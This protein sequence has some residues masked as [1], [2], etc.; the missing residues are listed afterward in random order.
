MSFARAERRRRERAAVKTITT[1]QLPRYVDLIEYVKLRTRCSTHT[2]EVVV[3]SGALRSE[4]H[5]LGT[6][7]VDGRT[8][9][10]RYVPVERCRDIQIVSPLAEVEDAD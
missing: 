1:Q 3:M 4:S 6:K 10:D 8:V 5:K 9:L 7:V 2:A